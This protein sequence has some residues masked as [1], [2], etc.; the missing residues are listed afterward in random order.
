MCGAW[1]RSSHGRRIACATNESAAEAGLSPSFDDTSTTSGAADP[2]CGRLV[3]RLGPASAS[4]GRACDLAR[5]AVDRPGPGSAFADL[6]SDRGRPD[7]A[8]RLGLDYSL[9][10]SLGLR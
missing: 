5:L 2:V 8:G 10:T 3:D 1:A 7:S 9:T 4:V 6:A